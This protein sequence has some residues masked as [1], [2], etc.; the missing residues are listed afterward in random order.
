MLRLGNRVFNHFCLLFHCTKRNLVLLY[1]VQAHYTAVCSVLDYILYTR[2]TVHTTLTPALPTSHQCLATRSRLTLQHYEINLTSI[3]TQS[4]LSAAID[5]WESGLHGIELLHNALANI[6]NFG[7][8]CI[9][10]LNRFKKLRK[11]IK[12]VFK[13]QI[14]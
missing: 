12:L 1:E 11:K 10:S 14:I 13:L 9:K 4:R 3:G 5:I 6:T 2:T 8:P 7:K